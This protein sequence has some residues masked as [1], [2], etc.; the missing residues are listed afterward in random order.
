MPYK[1]KTA[2]MFRVAN[3]RHSVLMEMKCTL[4]VTMLNEEGKRQ[5]FGLNL[6][7][8]SIQF[9]PISWTL[10]HIIDEQSPFFGMNY[11]QILKA[12]PEMM[13]KMKG[14][15]ETFTQEVHSRYSY[16]GSEVLFDRNFLPCFETDAEGNVILH[17]DKISDNA[18]IH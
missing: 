4:L 13:I 9:F 15:D 2:M 6:E 7:I 11:D 16:V 5:Y 3:Q 1:D 18:P 10:V 8:D 17:L 12:E 14:Y